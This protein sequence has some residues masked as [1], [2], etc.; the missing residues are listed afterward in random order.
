MKALVKYASGV[1]NIGIREMPEPTAGPGEVKVEVKYGGICGTDI[2]IY[3]DL[4][5]N[6]PPVIMGHEWSGVVVSLGD[7]VKTLKV[8]DRVT[9]I[10][11]AYTCGHCRYCLEG[12]VFL[13]TDRLSF[14]S[15][16]NGGFAKYAVLGEKAIR[17]LPDSVS[18]KAGALSEPL[19]CMVKAVEFTTGIMAGDVVLVSGP[20]PIGLLAAQ[21]AR[22]EGGYVV[23]A[24]TDVDAERLQVA[25]NLGIEVTVNVQHDNV[26]QI[27]K[28]L[29]NGY[30]ADVVLEC[31]GSPAATRMGIQVVRKEGKFTQIGLHEHPF[32][33]D[34]L[35]ILLK[36]LT[37]KASFASSLEAWDRAM[38]LLGQG[39]VQTEPVVSDILPLS[40][41]EKGFDKINRREGLKILLQPED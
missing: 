5:K 20:G 30:G 12:H 9:G 2:H 6:Y 37:F 1:G 22:A 29:T 36:D 40:D 23:L 14:G 13:C 15:G 33:L 32:E 26:D 4:Y 34:V 21:L 8:G 7:G 17:K 27:L 19:A 24:G 11:A 39:K 18:F 25:R 38:I 10:P 3:H 28:D 35:Q 41:W 16:R 31:S